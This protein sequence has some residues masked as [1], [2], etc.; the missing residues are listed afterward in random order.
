M[1]SGPWALTLSPKDEVLFFDAHF[2]SPPR[3]ESELERRRGMSYGVEA[4]VFAEDSKFPF[5]TP[6]TWFK[7]DLKTH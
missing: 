5:N 6:M 1:K 7:I 4:F 3:M 2:F